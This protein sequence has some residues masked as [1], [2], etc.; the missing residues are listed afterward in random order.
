MP[1]GVFQRLENV[2]VKEGGGKEP[3]FFFSLPIR[4]SGRKSAGYDKNNANN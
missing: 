3:F 1:T 2:E 4:V